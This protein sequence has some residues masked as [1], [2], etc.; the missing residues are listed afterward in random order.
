[1]IELELKMLAEVGLVGYP[2]A[3]LFSSDCTRACFEVIANVFACQFHL[4]KSTLLTALSKARPKIA[5]Y[6]FTTLFPSLG[7]AEFDG[8]GFKSLL[9]LGGIFV[10]YSPSTTHKTTRS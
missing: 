6:A 1:M 10:Y 2:N 5:D 3:G 8:T 9:L 4:G 7:V